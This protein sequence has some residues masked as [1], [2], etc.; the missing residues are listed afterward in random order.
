MPMGRPCKHPRSLNSRVD[1]SFEIEEELLPDQ[2]VFF[3]RRG[4][5]A[6][7][8]LLEGTAYTNSKNPD[9]GYSLTRI[10]MAEEWGW[11]QSLYV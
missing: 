11:D 6:H 2:S 7:A 1:F 3:F 10:A 5:P 8:P 9:S 4:A